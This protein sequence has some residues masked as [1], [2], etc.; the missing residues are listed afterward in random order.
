MRSHPLAS[1]RMGERGYGRGTADQ[2]AEFDLGR[3]GVMIFCERGIEY[4]RVVVYSS[5][6]HQPL[7]FFVLSD[8]L[9]ITARDDLSSFDNV[10]PIGDF[11][12]M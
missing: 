10:H 2:N 7:N 5:P 4:I 1:I 8:I 6:L 12:N 9:G 3:L 11:G